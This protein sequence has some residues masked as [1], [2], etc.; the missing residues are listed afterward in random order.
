M[1]GILLIST[2]EA[3]KLRKFLIGRLFFCLSVIFYFSINSIPL[4]EFFCKSTK[5]I[6][7]NLCGYDTPLEDTNSNHILVFKKLQKFFFS[8]F[9]DLSTTWG[10]CNTICIIQNCLKID[11]YREKL[12]NCPDLTILQL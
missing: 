10:F 4:N 9:L 12:V 8:S 5:T 1:T 7:H 3:W 11:I 6:L 2:L